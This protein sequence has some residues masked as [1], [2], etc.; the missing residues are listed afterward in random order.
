MAK[1]NGGDVIVS[2][3]QDVAE[4]R[5]SMKEMSEHSEALTEHAQALAKHARKTDAALERVGRLLKG[6]ADRL[7]DHER[8]IQAL[9]QHP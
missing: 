7:E 4:M 3:M 5:G 6:M 2:L 1:A 9:E 8:R